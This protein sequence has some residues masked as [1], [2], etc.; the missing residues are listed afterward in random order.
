M[1]ARQTDLQTTKS[2]A[3]AVAANHQALIL[4]G[5]DGQQRQLST[6]QTAAGT[7]SPSAVHVQVAADAAPEA[8]SA[9]PSIVLRT[10]TEPGSSSAATLLTHPIAGGNMGTLN[11]DEGSEDS[12][13]IS[14]AQQ[15]KGIVMVLVGRFVFVPT[16]AIALISV[17]RIF[18]PQWL[19]IMV[20]D[21]V[22]ILALLIL[23][24]TPPAINLITVSQATGKFETEAAQILFYGYILGIFVLAIEVSGFLWLTSAFAQM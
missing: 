10:A 6:S 2:A 15:R 5:R 11:E 14:I 13:S 9:I 12:Q 24:G 16:M 17:L 8:G 7:R 4:N 21:P 3:A 22:Y 1:M 19:P 18:F 23:S 20:N